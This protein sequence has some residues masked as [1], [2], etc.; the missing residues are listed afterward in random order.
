VASLVLLDQNY[1]R[2]LVELFRTCE[3]LENDEG[4]QLMFKIV[5]GIISL[6]DAHIF[7][8]IFSDEYIMDIVGA[9][10]HDPEL[11]TR[12]SHRT[13]LTEQVTFKE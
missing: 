3:D 11:T 1:I 12:Q 9:L 6:N 10:E 13:Y 5:K 7:D 8:I 4:L 2:K